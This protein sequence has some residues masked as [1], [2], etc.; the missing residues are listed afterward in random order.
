VNLPVGAL[1]IDHVTKTFRLYEE[2]YR[3]LKERALHL[4]RIPFREFDAVHDVHFE[5]RPGQMVGLLGHNGSGKSTLLKCIAGTMQPTAGSIR[6]NGRMAALLE[7]GAGF[8]PELTGRENLFLAGSIMGYSKRDISAVFDDIVDFAELEQFIDNQVKHYS[9][10]MFA[11]LGFALAVNVDPE[12]LLIDE[13]LA[14]GDEAFQQKCL[15]RFRTFREQGVTMLFVTHDTDL[16]STICDELVVLDHGRMIAHGDPVEA[17]TIYRRHLYGEDKNL[18]VDEPLTDAEVASADDPAS[19]VDPAAPVGGIRFNSL[20]LHVNGHATTTV[21]PDDIVTFHAEVVTTRPV[22]DLVVA[23]AIRDPARNLI[24]S[25]NTQVLD[26]DL[27]R[28]DGSVTV[29]FTF[30]GLALLNG[31][32]EVD[33]GA[34]SVDGTV[35]YA[36][37]DAAARFAIVGGA[38]H[39]GIAHLPVRGG[40]I[41]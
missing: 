27:G 8:H 6:L 10:G 22:D 21:R 11:R 26:V 31:M 32:Y 24:N 5:V 38:R 33:L 23:Y 40:V 36:Q 16:A 20:T 14:V 37:V 2:Q 34:H 4:G 28:L 19:V 7:L 3:T 30:D 9:S 25:S 29:T 17:A 15:D 35:R 41:K 18:Y 13:I 1:E 12:I 39:T